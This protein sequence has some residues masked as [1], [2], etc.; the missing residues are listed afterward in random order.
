MEGFSSGLREAWCRG[1]GLFKK[2]LTETEANPAET[3]PLQS[4][5]SP[6][7]KNGRPTNRQ[8]RKLHLIPPEGPPGPRSVSRSSPDPPPPPF[9]GCLKAPT[10][11]NTEHKNKAIRTEEKGHSEPRGNLEEQPTD[12]WDPLPPP[13]PSFPPPPSLPL[14]PPPSPSLPLPPPPSFPNPLP[15][16]SPRTLSGGRVAGEGTWVGLCTCTGTGP[17]LNT[18]CTSTRQKPEEGG[19]SAGFGPASNNTFLNIK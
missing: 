2:K 8:R 16:P 3:R 1:T 18:W 13:S 14:P 10:T 9:P 7:R 17:D 4:S 12:F 5:V 11:N 15:P 6:V 19:I